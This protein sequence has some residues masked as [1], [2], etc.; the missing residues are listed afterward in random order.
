MDILYVLMDG[1]FE[2]LGKGYLKNI[3]D[4]D[5]IRIAET[6]QRYGHLSCVERLTVRQIRQLWQ[7][8]YMQGDLGYDTKIVF[9]DLH[10]EIAWSFLKK[11]MSR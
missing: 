4:V 6:C 2:L 9:E 8:Y 7:L 5:N 1:S 10:E 11:Y 3:P